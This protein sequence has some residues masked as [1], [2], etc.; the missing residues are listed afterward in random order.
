MQFIE[1]SEMTIWKE[2]IL[3]N[4][5]LWDK[6]GLLFVLGRQGFSVTHG[7]V[8]HLLRLGFRVYL[9][10]CAIRFNVFPLVEALEYLEEDTETLLERIYVQRAFTPYQILDSTLQIES[11]FKENFIYVYLAPCKQF[12]DGDVR[13]EEAAFLLN[14]L[15][16]RFAKL[17]DKG[18]RMIISEKERYTSSI[19]PGALTHLQSI[20]SKEWNLTQKSLPLGYDLFGYPYYH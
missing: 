8:T 3:Q 18:L 4:D 10:D 7:L 9:V 2:D 6:K 20:A 5:L 17:R 13:G 1:Y 19:F 15:I 14:R 11:H 16:D 12:F